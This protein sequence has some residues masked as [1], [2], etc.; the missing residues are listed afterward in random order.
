MSLKA[1]NPQFTPDQVNTKDRKGNTA[2]FY[3]ARF[4]NEDFVDF[5]MKFGANPNLKCEKEFTPLHFGFKSNNVTLIL[6][7][8]T[9]SVYSPDLNVLNNDFKTPLAYCSRDV[10]KKLNLENG[11]AI[12]DSNYP[13]STFDN[14]TLLQR[15][16][17][18]KML[19]NY[20][21]NIDL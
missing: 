1:L 8:L 18:Y 6:K 16:E 19:N 4:R 9:S 3:A 13:S 15:E 5:L 17:F 10:L 11:V 21:V 14:N 20:E 2:L 12:A 7:L